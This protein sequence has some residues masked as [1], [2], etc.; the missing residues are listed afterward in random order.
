[1]DYS[2]TSLGL[3]CN[4]GLVDGHRGDIVAVEVKVVVKCVRGAHTAEG[5]GLK[6]RDKQCGADF[7][8]YSQSNKVRKTMQNPCKS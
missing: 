2:S 1:M 6:F 8:L 4:L 3:G 5:C 7:R